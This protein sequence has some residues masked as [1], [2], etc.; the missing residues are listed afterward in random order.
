MTVGWHL[1]TKPNCPSCVKAKGKLVLR[2]ESFSF[3][4]HTTEE[5]IEAFKAAG[6]RTFPRIFKD[7]ELIGGFEDLEKFLAEDDF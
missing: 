4:E 2:G 6:H 5:Q 3:L 1:L 7:G